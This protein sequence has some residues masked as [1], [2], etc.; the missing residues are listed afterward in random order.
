MHSKWGRRRRDV[1]KTTNHTHTFCEQV[2]ELW[3]PSDISGAL[4]RVTRILLQGTN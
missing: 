3:N 2:L 1:K 4:Y